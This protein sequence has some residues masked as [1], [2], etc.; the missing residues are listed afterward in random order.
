M[1]SHFAAE[2]VNKFEHNRKALPAIAL[3]DMANITSIANDRDYA[4]VFSRQIEALGKPDDIL[5]I[6][7]TS[8]PMPYKDRAEGYNHSLNV[9]FAEETAKEMGIKV[10]YAPRIE[11]STAAIQEFQ[12]EWMHQ[13]CREIEQAFI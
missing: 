13:L 8:E 2:L 1:S 4:S 11:D 9:V 12:L 3:N 5:I 6:F 7:T 10:F